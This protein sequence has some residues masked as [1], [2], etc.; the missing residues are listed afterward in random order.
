MRPIPNSVNGDAYSLLYEGVDTMVCTLDLEGRFTDV[1]RAGELLTGYSR[2]ELVGRNALELIAPDVRERAVD[3]FLGLLSGAGDRPP[4]QF[5][6]IARD[7]RRV[8]IEVTSTTFGQHGQPEGVLG[9]VRDLTERQNAVEA[10][11]RSEQRFRDSFE[12]AAIGMALVATD[13]RF[14]DAN[15]SLCEIL[16][17][18]P[19]E[20]VARTFQEITH[21]DDLDADLEYVRQMLAGEVSAYHMEKRYFHREG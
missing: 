4:D 18:S 15:S 21:P 1:N 13:G 5:V 19:A 16:G 10:L 6:L 20:L 8:P 12:S 11:R 17:Y 9:I 2:D 14:L 3:Q 7:G